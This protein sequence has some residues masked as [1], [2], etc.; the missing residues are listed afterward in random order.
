MNKNKI[1]IGLILLLSLF[2]LILMF[3]VFRPRF[4]HE[5][6]REIIIHKLKFDKA[7]IEQYDKLIQWHRSTVDSAQGIIMENK[8]NLYALVAGQKNDSLKQTYI[9]NISNTIA[10]IEGVNYAHFNDIGAICKPEQEKEFKE[11]TADL[12]KLFALGRKR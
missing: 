8:Q 7:Q 10:F 3:F 1:Y 2:N 5:K 9:Q 6:P 4:G 11:L 12:Q